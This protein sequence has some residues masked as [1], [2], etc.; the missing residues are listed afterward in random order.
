MKGLKLSNRGLCREKGMV[1][2]SVLRGLQKER[3]RERRERNPKHSR[4]K[5]RARKTKK[6]DT[7][8]C[9][10]FSGS[11]WRIQLLPLRPRRLGLEALSKL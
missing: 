10:V 9:L 2:S 3:E 5:E 6:A 11:S 4:A 1:S 7:G 8:R